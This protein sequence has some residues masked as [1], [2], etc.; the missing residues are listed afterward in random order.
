M[1]GRVNER[2]DSSTGC[3]EGLTKDKIPNTNAFQCVLIR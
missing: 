2:P 1:A 3:A